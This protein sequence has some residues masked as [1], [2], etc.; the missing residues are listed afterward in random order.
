VTGEIASDGSVRPVGGVEQKA[1][2]ARHNDVQLMLVP[3]SEVKDARKGA[4][5]MK[6]V[7]VA[8]IDDALTALAGAG[9]APVPPS[10]STAA[11][12]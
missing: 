12:S 6:V 2:T 4:D 1:I 7:G 3:M 8:N 9:G 11:R 5:G 10:S